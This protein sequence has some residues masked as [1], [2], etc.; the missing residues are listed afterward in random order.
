MTSPS[1]RGAPIINGATQ[2]TDFKKTHI[3]KQKG[4]SEISCVKRQGDCVTNRMF[5]AETFH[6]FLLTSGHIFVNMN[7]FDMAKDEINQ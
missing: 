1:N 3:Q 6:L 7:K 5:L 4:Y 2:I